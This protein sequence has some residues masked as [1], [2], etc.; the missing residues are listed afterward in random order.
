MANWNTIKQHAYD[1]AHDD[2]DS[3]EIAFALIVE[4]GIDEEDAQEIALDE[5]ENYLAELD[6]EDHWD[7]MGFNPYE[8]G[9]DWDC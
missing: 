5:V 9:Y 2:F 4:Y 7:E 3:S 6:E 1:L 8:G